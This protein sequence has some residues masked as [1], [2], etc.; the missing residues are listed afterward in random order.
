MRHLKLLPFLAMVATL[1]FFT[2][3]EINNCVKGEGEETTRSFSFSD[4]SGVSFSGV[5]E[6][7]LTERGAYGI[8]ATGKQNIV[9]LLDIEVNDGILEVGFKECVRDI[10]NFELSVT[11][12]RIE[13]VE[14]SGAGKITNTGTLADGSLELR[15][16]GAGDVDLSVDKDEVISEVTGAGKLKLT[17]KTNIHKVALHGAGKIVAYEL[18]TMTSELDISG[19]G[20][21]EVYAIDNLNVN[22]SGIGNVKYKGSPSVTQSI[23]GMGKVSAAD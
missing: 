12:P 14:L 10:G 1:F 22:L 18:E 23:S 8:S 13:S 11:A 20:N 9:D 15:V 19:A 17:G 21:A 16:S 4:F 5:G 6:I 3:C 2:A 7:R